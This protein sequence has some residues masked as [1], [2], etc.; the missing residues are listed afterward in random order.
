MFAS[1]ELH[2]IFIAFH[3]VAICVSLLTPSGRL[4]NNFITIY[5]SVS[6]SS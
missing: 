3:Y 2:K 5:L 4:A 6:L 1:Y